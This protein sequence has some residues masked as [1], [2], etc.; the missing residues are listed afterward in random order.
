MLK[1]TSYAVSTV[2]ILALVV[3][4]I[5][6]A[7]DVTVRSRVILSSIASGVLPLPVMP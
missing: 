4:G 7:S 5:V 6:R 1:I 2:I 3:D